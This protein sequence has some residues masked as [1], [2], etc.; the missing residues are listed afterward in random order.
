MPSESS[1][2][3]DSRTSA[4]RGSKSSNSST[5]AQRGSASG[6]QHGQTQETGG[7]SSQDHSGA[8]V[9]VKVF[10]SEQ[11]FA[12]IGAQFY[13]DETTESGQQR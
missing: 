4:Q 2:Q 5:K 8:K 3:K 10:Y 1:S 9:P 12:H 11:D 6:S 13:D 7:S